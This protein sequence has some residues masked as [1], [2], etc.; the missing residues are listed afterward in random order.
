MYIYKH[1]RLKLALSISLTLDESG[2]QA[3]HC[4]TVSQVTTEIMLPGVG[5]YPPSGQRPQKKCGESWTKLS[6]AA[7]SWLLGNSR[8]ARALV[9]NHWKALLPNQHTLSP[10]LQCIGFRKHGWHLCI[11]GCIWCPCKHLR[12]SDQSWLF[13][14]F[15]GGLH[16]FQGAIYICP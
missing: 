9:T 8:Q 6:V 16:F 10:L 2:S 12:P 14:I 3:C 5:L 1:V 7:E 13:A 4:A 11:G 15:L